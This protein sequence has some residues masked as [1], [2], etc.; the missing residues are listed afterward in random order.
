MIRV[1]LSVLCLLTF[2][3]T[4]N[5]MQGIRCLWAAEA[6]PNILTIE[7]FDSSTKL[8]VYRDIKKIP[9]HLKKIPEHNRLMP[10]FLTRGFSDE[11]Y[12]LFTYDTPL[13]DKFIEN[14][15]KLNK[16]PNPYYDESVYYFTNFVIL[17]LLNKFPNENPSVLDEFR[18]IIASQGKDLQAFLLTVVPMYRFPEMQI[19]RLER[20]S[21]GREYSMVEYSLEFN[22]R[23]SRPTTKLFNKALD[24]LWD[25]NTQT[26]NIIEGKAIHRGQVKRYL[27]YY[28][29]FLKNYYLPVFEI[30]IHNHSDKM[31]EVNKI[32]VEVLDYSEYPGSRNYTPPSDLISVK[33][34]NKKGE[35]FVR[36][37]SPV[38]IPSNDVRQL[39]F[40][41]DDNYNSR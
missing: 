34:P 31:Q 30:T 29:A 12:R 33:V 28:Y 11:K 8:S 2:F 13:V 39:E 19:Y 15:D 17:Y 1:L 9:E 32:G 5:V 3:S 37:D 7:G 18:Q 26:Y 41:P 22:N 27:D 35:K 20:S 4:V 24:S 36:L 6:K 23:Q 25:D 14:V 10:P 38:K 40:P 21:F 16:K